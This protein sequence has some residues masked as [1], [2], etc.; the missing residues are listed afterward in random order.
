MTLPKVPV[1]SIRTI[2]YLCPSFYPFLNLKC[3]VFL[4][5]L[6][7][8]DTELLLPDEDEEEEEGDDEEEEEG[9]RFL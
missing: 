6:V 4:R 5:L 7:D 3:G 9:D 2:L 1:P 8:D